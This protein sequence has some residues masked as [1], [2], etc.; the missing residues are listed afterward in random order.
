MRASKAI[1]I[2][3]RMCADRTLGSVMDP[4]ETDAL[5]VVLDIAESSAELPRLLAPGEE[6]PPGCTAERAAIVAGPAGTMPVVDEA[7]GRVYYLPGAPSRSF[8][9]QGCSSE[10]IATAAGVAARELVAEHGAP[11]GTIVEVRLVRRG[12]GATPCLTWQEPEYGGRCRA[13]GGGRAE[14]IERQQAAR[15]GE[16]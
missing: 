2:V 6:I 14:H 3:R 1:E 15:A 8:L 16:A 13:C 11:A 5:S 10:Q 4:A 9:P 7:R 12:G